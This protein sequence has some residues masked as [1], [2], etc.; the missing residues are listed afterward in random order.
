[1]IQRSDGPVS[2][3]RSFGVRQMAS[4]VVD[5]GGALGAADRDRLRAAGMERAAGR[6]VDW[7]GRFAADRRSRPP[8]H[9]KVGHGVEQHAGVRVARP[10]EQ[11]LGLADLDEPAEIHHPDAARHETHHREIVGDEEI[12]EAEPV[13]QITHQIEDLRLDG[14]VE[15]R[16]RLVADD[17]IGVGGDRPRNRDPLALAAGEFVRKLAPVG[18]MEADEFEQFADPGDRRAFSGAG[19]ARAKRPDRLGD[20]VADP[21]ARIERSVREREGRY[22]F[23][24]LEAEAQK[25]TQEG[26]LSEFRAYEEIARLLRAGIVPTSGG[27]TR[28]GPLGFS[29]VPAGYREPRGKDKAKHAERKAEYYRYGNP[30]RALA[31]HLRRTIRAFRRGRDSVWFRGRRAEVV[32][33]R[34]PTNPSSWRGERLSWM[35]SWLPWRQSLR[36][37]LRMV[38]SFRATAMRATNFGLA[39]GDDAVE[40][41]RV[42]AWRP[43]LL[44]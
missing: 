23:A 43:I 15:G 37:A 12:G 26:G 19:V 6:G 14:H 3:I 35:S 8:A 28:V 36:I 34:G 33:A 10:R 25:R 30:D 44:L 29:V 31:D 22:V 24:R 7:V 40:V 16:G 42:L 17:E 5:E 32:A 20:D 13:L 4:D 11:R 27:I 41:G 1:V 9:H 39:G 21:P 2:A 18:R 38:R